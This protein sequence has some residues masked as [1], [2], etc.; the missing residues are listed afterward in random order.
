MIKPPSAK[1]LK[2]MTCGRYYN[3]KQIYNR[4]NESY[5]DGKLKKPIT[6]GKPFKGRRRRSIRFGYVDSNAGVIRINPSLDAKFVPE[7]FVE[8]IVF[9]EMLHCLV[10]A[11]VSPNGRTL[12]HHSGFRKREKEYECYREAIKWQDENIHRFL[13]R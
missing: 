9:H 13:K 11:K 1:P 12:A 5:F 2:T 7:Y 8:F 6:W 3:L 4:L 10:D